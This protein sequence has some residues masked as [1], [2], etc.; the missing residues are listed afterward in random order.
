MGNVPSHAHA[1]IRH[2]ANQ[3]V[4]DSHD[5][6][7]LRTESGTTSKPLPIPHRVE[8][9]DLQH[10]EPNSSIPSTVQFGSPLPS[11]PNEFSDGKMTEMI[12]S[13]SSAFP[14]I[15]PSTYSWHTKF[16]SSSDDSSIISV[17]MILN[18]SNGGKEVY[19]TGT[20]TEWKDKLPLLET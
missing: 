19:I 15:S 17:P 8:R 6:K 2:E 9:F 7:S 12:L 20:F 16:I 5:S 1:K 11:T 13:S 3:N 18:W 14:S 10:K 4:S